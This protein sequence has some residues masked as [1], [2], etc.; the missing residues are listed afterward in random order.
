MATKNLPA[1]VSKAISEIDDALNDAI[2]N[3]DETV[4]L[5]VETVKV[6]VGYM[7]Q[8]KGK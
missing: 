4:V 3:K 1:K 5:D 6:L 8:L 7:S 2:A